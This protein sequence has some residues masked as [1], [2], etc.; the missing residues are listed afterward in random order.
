MTLLTFAMKEENGR[1]PSRAKDH[2]WREEVAI[3]L[4]TAEVKTTITILVIIFVAV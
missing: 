4:M 2:S 1:P 3:S